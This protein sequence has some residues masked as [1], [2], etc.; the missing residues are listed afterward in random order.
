L[1]YPDTTP[2]EAG[3][4]MELRLETTTKEAACA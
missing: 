1:L 4:V 3:G 2:P